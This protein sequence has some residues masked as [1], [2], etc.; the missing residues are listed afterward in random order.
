MYQ[1]LVSDG[2]V[3]GLGADEVYHIPCDVL[4]PKQGEVF[5]VHPVSEVDEDPHVTAP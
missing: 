2:L 3:Q 5:Y 1:S 4:I